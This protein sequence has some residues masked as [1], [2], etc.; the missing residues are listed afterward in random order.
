MGGGQ[1]PKNVQVKSKTHETEVAVNAQRTQVK[2]K[3]RERSEV[4]III[5]AQTYEPDT[6][7]KSSYIPSHSIITTISQIL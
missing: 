4:L 2:Q 6:A 5:I 1:K 7:Q 3:R